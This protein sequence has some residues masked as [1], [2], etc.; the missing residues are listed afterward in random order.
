MAYQAN[1][2]Q[3][4]DKLSK[5]QAD[6]QGNF[7]ALSTQLNPTNSTVLFPTRVGDPTAIATTL[8]LYAKADANTVN[9]TGLFLRR[10]T[11]ASTLLTIP[12]T[13]FIANA[14]AGNNNGYTYLPSGLL[15]QWGIAQ[16]P[17]PPAT[18][19]VY[20]FTQLPNGGA[21]LN[22]DFPTACFF[23]MAWPGPGVTNNPNSFTVATDVIDRTSFFASG[24]QGAAFAALPFSFLAVGI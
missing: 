17:T 5:S 8:Q 3:A 6:I 12:L 23:V 13:Q 16:V 24:H 22:I 1:I 7:Q 4:N 14:V 18:R 2:P 15:V 19:A 11:G 9:G 21:P 10:A 20:Q